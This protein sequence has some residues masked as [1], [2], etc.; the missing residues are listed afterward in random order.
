MNIISSFLTFPHK[1]PLLQIHTYTAASR[2]VILL[3]HVCLTDLI[4]VFLNC[5][6]RGYVGG[7][8]FLIRQG[9]LQL[10]FPV[11]NETWMLRSITGLSGI[12]HIH[13]AIFIACKFDQCD[14]LR[15][16]GES[17][18][19]WDHDGIVIR[20]AAYL[21][22]QRVL[23]YMCSLEPPV[24]LKNCYSNLLP[25]AVQSDCLEMVKKVLDYYPLSDLDVA[26]NLAV[27]YCNNS[28]LLKV[29]LSYTS[30]N[31]IDIETLFI[32]ACAYGRLPMVQTMIEHGVDLQTHFQEACLRAGDSAHWNIMRYLIDQ[33]PDVKLVNGWTFFIHACRDGELEIVEFVLPVLDDSECC[34]RGLV[35]ACKYGHES[36][37]SVLLPYLPTNSPFA[38]D[39]LVQASSQGYLNIVR[40]LVPTSQSCLPFLPWKQQYPYVNPADNFNIAIR[41]ARQNEHWDVYDYLIQFPGVRVS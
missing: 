38:I 30:P 29:L 12:E 22:S 3:K 36:V 17:K 1:K 5:C 39:A 37:V 24:F 16:L 10:P 13:P 40:L 21:G 18:N 23:S 20:T 41:F 14:V 31:W 28:E 34:A 15:E 4:P 35:Q 6:E 33:D 8:R 19:L 7:V 32:K 27:A 11:C 2:T 25:A 9:L 26:L